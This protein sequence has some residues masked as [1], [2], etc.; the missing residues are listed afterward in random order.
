VPAKY[1]P[2]EAMAGYRELLRE[3]DEVGPETLEAIMAK[4]YGLLN[5]GAA[6]FQGPPCFNTWSHCFDRTIFMNNYGVRTMPEGSPFHWWNWNAPMWLGINTINVDGRTTTL[7]GSCYWG[8]H[9]V[10]KLRDSIEATL[11]D[12]FIAKAPGGVEVPKYFK[13]SESAGQFETY[14]KTI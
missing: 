5:A 8:I 13:T 3:L 9:V 6:I 2:Q 11:R 10:E 4:A 1:G 12:E 14:G 7:V